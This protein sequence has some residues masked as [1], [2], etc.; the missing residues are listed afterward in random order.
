MVR[1]VRRTCLLLLCPAFAAA[2]PAAPNPRLTGTPFMRVWQA[3]DHGAEPVNWDVAPHPDGRVY[4]GNNAGVLEF[5]GARW[6]TLPMPQGGRAA[7]VAIDTRGRVWAG[8]HDQ[9]ARFEPDARGSLRAVD[10]TGIIG[11][12]NLPLGSILQVVAVPDGIYLRN[13]L[14]VYRLRDTGG[15]WQVK[16]WET[17]ERFTSIWRLGDAVYGHTP[18]TLVRFGEDGPVPVAAPLSPEAATFGPA[19]RPVLAARVEPDGSHMLLSTVGPMRWRGPGAEITPLSAEATALF[20]DES[21]QAATFLPDGRMAFAMTRSGLLFLDA[22]GRPQQRLTRAH[23]LPYNRFEALA[24]DAQGGIWVALHY[25]LARLQLDSPFAVHGAAQGVEGGSR[26][27]ARQW[28]QLFVTHGEGA[29]WRDAVTGR[30]HPV[31]GLRIGGNRLLA[32]GDRLLLSSGGLKEITP[33]HRAHVRWNGVLYGIVASRLH[34]GWLFGGGTTGLVLF[35]PAAGGSSGWEMHGRVH[36]LRI[37]IENVHD[38]GDGFVWIASQAGEI[39][40]A[41]FRGGLSLDAPVEKFGPDRGVPPVGRSE[42]IHFFALGPELCAASS[43]WLLRFDAV[44]GRFVPETRITG[45]GA[46]RGAAVVHAAESGA[47]WFWTT[48]GGAELV[49]ATPTTAGGWRTER[50]SIAP[51]E[52]LVVNSVFEDAAAR[53]LWIA[54]QGVL[55]SMDLDWSPVQPPPPLRAHVRRIEAQ[56]GEAL[57]GGAAGPGA[58]RLAPLAPT[59]RSLRFE[60][61]APAHAADVSGRSRTH[62]RT[63]LEGFEDGWTPWTAEPHR[64]FTNLPF[65]DLVFR[66]QARDLAGRES[67]ETALAFSIAPPWWLTRWARGGYAVAVISG[68]AGLILLRTRTLRR[69]NEQ[70]EAVV[71]AR[72]AELERLRRIDRDESAAAKL[73]EEKARL[74]VLRYQLN[75][76]FLYN[77]LGSIRSLV[78]TRPEE[79][80]DMTTQLADFCRMTLTRRDDEAGTLA[81]ELKM[82]TAYLEMERTRWRERLQMRVDA[83]VAACAVRLPPFLLLPLIENAI[84]YGVRTSEEVVQVTVTARRRADGLA[85]EVANTGRWVDAPAGAPANGNST[86]IGL[87]N[88]RQRLQRY[89]PDAHEFTTTTDNGWV[90]VTLRLKA[91][92]QSS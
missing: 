74:E 53:T 59:Q 81:D 33:D 46:E 73:A 45:L 86:G 5:D 44:A 26:R 71:A 7:C 80:D 77:A 47:L 70:L 56:E 79:A 34:P 66:V 40:R 19:P 4:V 8:G 89:Y 28:E 20:R 6:R 18:Q 84:K 17:A 2:E 61:A 76:H 64:D 57:F 25:G 21:A 75:P 82:I 42:N 48:K 32:Y 16:V 29:S 24:P 91:Q 31:E 63:R 60:F 12:E 78:H 9:I 38:T 50:R 65:R 35:R 10:L 83:D 1:G 3:E 85:I 14:R 68:V 37:D 43:D 58:A 90:R 52:N 54:G 67:P 27:F 15:G 49:S 87:E 13:P 23:G 92:A 72:T 22:Q 30:F 41:D 88:L 51:L 11:A 69:R 36:A 39:W 62:Y 55:V